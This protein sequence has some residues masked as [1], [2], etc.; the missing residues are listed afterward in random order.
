VYDLH[1]MASFQISQGKGKWSSP[2]NGTNT[3]A[4][5]KALLD[6]KK[7]V[8]V[9]DAKSKKTITFRQGGAANRGRRLATLAATS[10]SDRGKEAAL[11]KA[12]DPQGVK[13]TLAAREGQRTRRL[14]AGGT[15]ISPGAMRALD[16]EARNRGFR[17]GDQ[18]LRLSGAKRA[19]TISTTA[20]RARTYAKAGRQG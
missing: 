17:S 19:G 15:A 5:V 16:A 14:G 20:G 10:A 9:R 18:V 2:S 3:L 4:D 6:T 8:R 1:T 12:R 11:R 7:T 13:R